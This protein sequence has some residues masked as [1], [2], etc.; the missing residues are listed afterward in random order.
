[1][2]IAKTYTMEEIAT[3]QDDMEP[4]PR[5]GHAGR[6]DWAPS[7]Y[8]VR[9]DWD[10]WRGDLPGHG[11]PPDAERPH[12]ECSHPLRMTRACAKDGILAADDPGIGRD[13]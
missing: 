13:E 10:F 7:Q 5:L 4:N 12:I 11:R 2:P 9:V 1:M 3:T 8:V 6:L